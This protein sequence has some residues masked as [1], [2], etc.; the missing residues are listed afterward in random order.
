MNIYY[1]YSIIYK[2]LYF[3][4]EEQKT[5]KKKRKDIYQK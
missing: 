4:Y 5:K 1:I 2:F 3:Y